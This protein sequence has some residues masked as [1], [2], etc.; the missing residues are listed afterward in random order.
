MNLYSYFMIGITFAVMSITI[1]IMKQTRAG[2]LVV[3][4]PGSLLIG[5]LLHIAL[6]PLVIVSYLLK[7]FEE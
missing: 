1:E 7:Q 4:T 5:L 2:R 6:W 3:M